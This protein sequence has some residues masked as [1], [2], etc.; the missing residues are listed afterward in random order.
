YVWDRTGGLRSGPGIKTFLNQDV[1][2]LE[3]L[4]E[5]F[6]PR[7]EIELGQAGELPTRSFFGNYPNAALR[8]SA[9]ATPSP[10]RSVQPSRPRLGPPQLVYIIGCPSCGKRFE[11]K[12]RTTQLNPHKNASG[13]NCL[14][15]MGYV[16]EQ[17][18][19]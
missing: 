7:F 10:R 11:R 4:E 1:E 17:R 5:H 12:T 8:R 3:L 6:E 9:A 18:Y 16:V 13:W 15:R 2:I 14:G 19:Q